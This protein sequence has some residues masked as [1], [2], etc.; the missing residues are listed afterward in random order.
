M[1]ISIAD[2]TIID[3]EV[4]YRTSHDSNKNY[5]YV[6]S[7]SALSDRIFTKF[8][9]PR[10]LEFMK[11]ADSINLDNGRICKSYKDKIWILS[12]STHFRCQELNSNNMT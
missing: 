10:N 3:G 6:I 8:M 11:N 2:K 4:F 5:N 12:F 9:Y 1:F 7:G